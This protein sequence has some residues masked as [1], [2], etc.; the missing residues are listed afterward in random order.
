MDYAMIL[1]AI[2]KY[3]S[4]TSVE[5]QNKLKPI[6][7]TY[8]KDY[9]TERLGITKHYIYRISKKWFAEKGLRVNFELYLKIMAMGVNPDYTGKR[10]YK[11]TGIKRSKKTPEEV[12]EARREYQRRYYAEVTKKKR[13]ANKNHILLEAHN[14]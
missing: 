8:N 14:G 4:M 6:I 13:A 2:N 10:S 12:A 11:T 1:E 3:N 9:L 5:I 7:K